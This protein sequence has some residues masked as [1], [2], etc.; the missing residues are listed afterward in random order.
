M[1]NINWCT[2][3]YYPASAFLLGRYN[4]VVFVRF[5]PEHAAQFFKGFLLA[6]QR[7]DKNVIYLK[8]I[9]IITMNDGNTMPYACFIF[10]CNHNET[11]IWYHFLYKFVSDI[12]VNA[13][14]PNG[15]SEAFAFLSIAH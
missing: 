11:S 12:T 8:L 14:A 5:T 1:D 15:V 3:A 2:I 13:C 9:Q 4:G 10:V 7:C 6:W